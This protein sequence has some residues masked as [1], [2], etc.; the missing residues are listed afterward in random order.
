ML[1]KANIVMIEQPLPAKR[2]EDLAWL[3]ER[4]PL[5]LVADEDLTCAQDLR[6]L[7]DVYDGV[8]I[9]LMKIGGLQPAMQMIHTAK[10]LGLKVMLGCMIESSLGITAA[11]HLSPLANWIDLDGSLLLREDPFHGVT[12]DQGR[13]SIP[14]APG[15]GAR[16]IR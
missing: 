16:P 3:R 6:A 2:F 5:P 10:S 7:A 1:E 9:K 13:P 8:N 15:I 14:N 11:A 4:T 12:F